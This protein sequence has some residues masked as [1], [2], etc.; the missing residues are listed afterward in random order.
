ML[1]VHPQGWCL[2]V[3]GTEEDRVPVPRSRWSEHGQLHKTKCC[4][5][6]LSL[7]V[8]GAETVTWCKSG[9]ERGFF[10]FPLAPW[11]GSK[12]EMEMGLGRGGYR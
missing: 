4:F 3:A 2:I 9:Q 11:V 6:S 10:R 7:G 1:L 8:R 12:K 5:P